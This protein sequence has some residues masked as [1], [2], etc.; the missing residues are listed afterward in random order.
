MRQPLSFAWGN[1]VW[2]TSLDDAWA[3]YRVE[4]QSYAGLSSAA[5]R[6][7]LTAVAGFAFAVGT[8]FQLLRVSRPW[9]VA[10][11]REQVENQADRRWAHPAALGRYLDLHHRHLGDR[12][13]ARPEV[14]V[15]VRLPA[16]GGPT[17]RGWFALG[18]RRLGLADPR[19]I[20]RRQLDEARAAEQRV[21]S[22]AGDYL[23]CTRASTADLQWLVRRAFCRGVAEPVVEEQ[24]APNALVV[25]A[26]E[27]DGCAR[28]V[29]L[30]T[31]VMR[32]CDAPMH[33]DAR[34]LRISGEPGESHQAFLML[35][36]LPEIA[37]FPGPQAELLFAPLEAVPFEVDAA[38]SARWVPN[39]QA[40]ALA[41][42]K[43]V[44]ADNVFTEETYGDHG[45]TSSSAVRPGIARE[46]EEY[47][48]SPE[49]PPLLRASIGLCV[50][51]PSA[52]LLDERVERLRREYAPVLL[53]RPLGSQV[54][55]FVSHLPA[56]ARRVRD[57]DDVLLCE[58]LGAMVPTATHAVG[59]D[60]GMYV[61]YTLSGSGQ[62]VLFDLTEASRT[63]RPA[64]VLCSGTL[65]SGKTLTAELLA[66]QAFL[67]GSRVV[68]IDP[69]GDH[70]LHEL[71]G[72]ER[73]EIIELQAGE[74]DRGRLDPLRIA[75][76]QT[77]ADLAYS[78][79]T[80]LLPAP[81]PPDWQTAIREA[82]D[83]C[84]ER[85]A[86]CCGEVVA[87]L[88]AGDAHAKAAGKALAVHTRS[89]LLQLGFA[90]S[91]SVNDEAGARQLSSLRIANL[92]LPLPGTSRS[93]L[94][95]DERAGQALLRLLAAYA[96]HLM[97]DDW[98]RHKV[99]LFDEAWMLLGDAA[100]RSLVDRIN[101]LCRSQNATPILAT[102]SLADVSELEN[103][104][105]ACLCFGVETEAEAA[106]VLNLLGLDADDRRLRTQLQSFRQGRCLMR[107][108]TGR[109]APVQID[110]VDEQLLTTL[111]TTPRGGI[112]VAA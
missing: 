12:R 41:R 77:R 82:V 95:S 79:L 75:P 100:G 37:A 22:C 66:Y 55:L 39:D 32:L 17:A 111:D 93:E 107:D 21:F 15:A 4:T 88:R 56:Q 35:G 71:V 81:V 24:W 7:L 89:G 101:R 102:Q 52:E 20:S 40:V 97:G 50:A 2:G 84:S 25:D 47:L 23:D 98:S 8:D 74:R 78:F 90:E 58:Q 64:A 29:P 85:G 70:R 110:L 49:R 59:S 36:A 3:L 57:Y 103:L 72:A 62:P 44:D 27:E 73:V 38:V 9:S 28:Y 83:A 5:K 45:P 108:Y 69:K 104:I 96:L 42:R 105:G 86:R 10:G 68:A 112:H 60:R 76:P 63:S 46:L 31:D 53:H 19:G 18:G 54:D 26:P 16:V 33:V 48:T 65:G 34:A 99:L 94:T 109:V 91:G 13:V 11:Y 14:Y 43:L 61:G 30:R 92:T 1:L 80:D 106:R 51:A 87:E 67:Q 6:D